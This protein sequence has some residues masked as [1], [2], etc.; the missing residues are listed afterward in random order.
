[1]AARHGVSVVHTAATATRRQTSSPT[2]DLVKVLDVLAH[3]AKE[4]QLASGDVRLAAH[5]VWIADQ[6]SALR[7]RVLLA[8]DCDDQQLPTSAA[9][10]ELYQLANLRNRWQG[11]RQLLDA[12]HTAE[13]ALPLVYDIFL[14]AE[15]INHH[16]RASRALMDEIA[17]ATEQFDYSD[18]G[19]ASSGADVVNSI[20]TSLPWSEGTAA[21]GR[22]R[23]TVCAATA[24]ATGAPNKRGPLPSTALDFFRI[25]HFAAVR[26]AV[27]RRVMLTPEQQLQ[28]QAYTASL[29]AA[30]SARQ[31]RE[32][33]TLIA[34]VFAHVEHAL[35]S[36]AS[37]GAELA[38][39]VVSAAAAAAAAVLPPPPPFPALAVSGGSA[40]AEL[41]AA[42]INHS[43]EAAVF[44]TVAAKRERVAATNDDA[45]AGK[46]TAPP[47]AAPRRRRHQPPDEPQRAAPVAAATPTAV[48]EKRFSTQPRITP[49]M[50]AVATCKRIAPD[51][52]LHGRLLVIA[53]RVVRVVEMAVGAGIAGAVLGCTF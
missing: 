45:A 4:L 33:A 14:S 42:A 48:P 51:G 13:A 23:Q 39:T 32:R 1:V 8:A 18:G 20:I 26:G 27:V 36:A 21:G 37:A 47:A 2:P 5:C 15:A 35:A 19:G 24:A 17:A 3:D 38:A 31:E 29:N 6:T 52:S 53:R 11:V 22:Q 44:Q 12:P 10:N 40:A 46:G 50:A 34:A 25:A 9:Q 43:A 41:D 49:R 28:W 30:E 16:P 7:A